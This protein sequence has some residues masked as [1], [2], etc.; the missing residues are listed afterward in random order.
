MYNK[1][2]KNIIAMQMSNRVFFVPKFGLMTR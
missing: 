1:E 2:F